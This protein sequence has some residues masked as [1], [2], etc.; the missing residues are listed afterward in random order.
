MTTTSIQQKDMGKAQSGVHVGQIPES[1]KRMAK[2]R[3]LADARAFLVWMDDGKAYALRLSELP[4]SDS[5]TVSKWSLSKGGD[6]IKVVQESGNQLDIPW[7][8]V[9]YHCEPQYK[10]YKGKQTEH[11]AGNAEKIGQR[12]RQIRQKNGYSIQALAAKS[13]MKR[14][15]LSRL[16]HGHHRPSLETLE[17]IA[18][19]LDVPVVDLVANRGK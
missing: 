8:E 17:K 13:G 15:N 11:P 14:P 7:D 10:Y 18:G 19:A 12:V 6:Y 16:E 5:S 9:L 2:V 3:F 1:M 4:E